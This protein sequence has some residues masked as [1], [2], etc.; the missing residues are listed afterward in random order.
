MFRQLE[1]LGFCFYQLNPE[2]FKEHV[3]YD[4]LEK[5]MIKTIALFE[6]RM[7]LDKKPNM[8]QELIRRGLCTGYSIEVA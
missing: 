7:R 1:A 4:L 2:L 6:S 8:V 3:T 5:A